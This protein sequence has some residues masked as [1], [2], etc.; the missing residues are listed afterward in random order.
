[1]KYAIEMKNITMKFGDFKAND[2]VTFC[3]KEGDIHAL[4]GENGAGKSTLMSILFG[5]YKPTIG[6]I[7]INGF[8]RE[9]KNPIQATKYGIGMVH[10]HFKLVETFTIFENIILNVEDTFL[11]I[12][13]T[14]R[15][16]AKIQHIMD[17]Y[18]FHVDL[19]MLVSD[20][21]VAEQQRTEILKMLYRDSNILI[22]DEPTAVLTPQQ[23]DEFLDALIN[24]KSFGKTII[25]IS[26]KLDE[27]KKVADAGTIIRRGKIISDVNPKVDSKEYISEL[28]V[29]TSINDVKSSHSKSLDKWALRV[30]GISVSKSHQ[31]ILGLKN[32]SMQMNY[33][34]IVAIAGVE[35]NGQ[36]ELINS[37]AGLSKISSGQILFNSLSFKERKKCLRAL[38]LINKKIANQQS[39][40]DPKYSESDI[41][42]WLKE[43]EEYE[44]KLK[45]DEADNDITHKS[46]L[47]RYKDGFSFIP[48]DRHKHGLVLNFKNWENIILHDIWKPS[49]SKWGV[50]KFNKVKEHAEIIR[51][52]YDVRSAEGINSISRSLSGGN[53]QKLIVGRELDND[54]SKLIIISQPTR[55]LDV[56]AISNIH[57]QI[58]SAKSAGKAILIISY[59]LDEILSL[60]DKIIVLNNG[61]KIDELNSTNVTKEQ[62]GQLMM[63]TEEGAKNE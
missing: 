55:G 23:I 28:M 62:L 51:E 58:L 59:E 49:Y 37:I 5:L 2:N 26:H 13:Q 63:T 60:A 10:Q 39:K 45:N 3:V 34:E 14:K 33:G 47:S 6:N 29:G 22:F 24:L 36:D 31:K 7:F 1:M 35:G 15:A 32:F 57:K 40:P 11:D 20:A 21:T 19:D 48:Q 8:E 38:K 9:V 16:R 25:I 12:V 52:K 17:K 50:I 41:D 54:N 27:L 43:K 44:L 42:G 53:Q 46:I 18:H 61:N 4:I 30:N 56:G